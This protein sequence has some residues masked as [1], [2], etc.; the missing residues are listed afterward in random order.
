MSRVL[1]R[2]V[3]LL[4][5]VAVACVGKGQQPHVLYPVD[6]GIGEGE[7]ALL[8]GHVAEVD[9]VPVARFGSSFA[10]A[11]GCH[12]VRTRGNWGQSGST[13][14]VGAT[15]PQ[16]YFAVPMQ[17]GYRYSVRIFERTWQGRG[18]VE[19]RMLEMRPS[20]EQVREIGSAQEQLELQQC[21]SRND[22]ARREQR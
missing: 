9:G 4:A 21:V 20:G 11:P 18:Y 10:V 7:A 6:A 15:L 16:V 5:L 19:L 3:V 1:S 2:T 14:A 8:E 12:I 13:W 22:E 17:P